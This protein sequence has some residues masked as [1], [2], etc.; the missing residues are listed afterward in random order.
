MVSELERLLS[1][2]HAPYDNKCFAAVVEMK[3]GKT[4]SGVTVKNQIYRDAIYA[5]QTAIARAV[6]A[7]YKYGDF[8]KIYIM[9]GTKNIN[10]LRYIN[11]DIILE[12]FEPSA[13]VILYDLNRNSRVMKAGNLVL[14]IYTEN[15]V[16]W[17]FYLKY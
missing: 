9:V 6:A 14:N 7:G 4:F 2:A 13:S 10:D 15:N 1:H 12:F 16:T 3:D 5:E 8:D 11:R 17:L